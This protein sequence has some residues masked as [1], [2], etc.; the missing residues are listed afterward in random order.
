MEN[1]RQEGAAGKGTV[2]VVDDSRPMRLLFQSLLKRDGY[3]A[4]VTEWGAEACPMAKALRP[5][6]ILLDV[7]LPDLSGYEVCKA[8]KEDEETRDIPVVF[9]SGLEEVDECVKGLRLGALD[10][11]SKPVNSKILLIKVATFVHLCRDDRMLKTMHA[12]LISST[13]QLQQFGLALDNASDA[14]VI[15]NPKGVITYCNRSFEMLTHYFPQVRTEQV[16]SDYFSDKDLF[17]VNCSEA[18]GG[19]PGMLEITME[20]AERQVPVSVKC[21]AIFDKEGIPKGLLF[22]IFDLSERKKAD[23]ERKRLE[24]ELLE[25]HKLES[26]GQLASGIAHEINTPVQFIGDNLHFLQD[27]TRDLLNLQLA[28]K[29]LLDSAKEKGVDMAVTDA[30][31][32]ALEVADIPYLQEELPLAISQSLEGVSRVASI[33]L[34]MK[35]FAHPGTTEKAPANLNE[36]IQTTITVARNKWKYVASLE[37]D[38]DESLPL[39]PCLV[40]EFNQVVLNLIVNAS[41]AIQ[42]KVGDSGEKGTIHISTRFCENYVE[43]RVE[44]SGGG[45]PKRIQSRIFEPFFTTKEVGKGSGQGLPIARAVIVNKHQG[46]FLFETEEGKGTTFIIHLP[47]E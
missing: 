4:Y 44:D 7:M 27:A 39:V 12:E 22:L 34:A 43:V 29:A 30:V 32:K 20:S 41:D 23:S 8:L 28:Q 15:T 3:D 17:L 25:A 18:L 45:I 31:D 38:F 9:V 16:I 10:F 13:S 40:S 1:N 19:C 46:R 6:L 5:H 21:S 11:I 42:E 35:E 37:T 26:V 36:A 14:V 47:V 24:M 2:L 33:V